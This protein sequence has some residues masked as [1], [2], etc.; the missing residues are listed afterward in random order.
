MTFQP[1]NLMNLSVANRDFGRVCRRV[2]DKD[3]VII[4]KYGEPALL[5]MDIEKMGEA[6]DKMGFEL[7]EK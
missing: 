6:L 2:K 7:Y 3:F 4:Q 1:E 5:I